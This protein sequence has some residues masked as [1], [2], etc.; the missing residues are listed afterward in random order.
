MVIGWLGDG[1]VLVMKDGH[2]MVMIR[3]GHGSFVQPGFFVM[4]WS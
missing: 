4:R 2:G 3:G 1:H